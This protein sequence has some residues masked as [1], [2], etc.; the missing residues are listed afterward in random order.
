MVR[1]RENIQLGQRVEE[2]KVDVWQDED[3][4]L[5]G[6][7]T[8]IGPCRILRLYASATTNRVRLRITRSPVSP[9]ISEFGLHLEP[10]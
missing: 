5:V 4:R 7:G 1:I 2:F 6:E 10:A 9:A 8:S 3:W